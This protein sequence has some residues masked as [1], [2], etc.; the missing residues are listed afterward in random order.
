MFFKVKGVCGRKSSIV[1]CNKF[2][3]FVEY[4]KIREFKESYFQKGL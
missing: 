2:K 4:D 1:N 3:D